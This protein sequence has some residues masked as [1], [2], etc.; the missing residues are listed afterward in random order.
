MRH[1]LNI[2]LFRGKVMFHSQ[3]SFCVFNDPM[4]YQ[5]CDVMMSISTWN[6][7]H[8]RIY[9]LNRNLLSHQTWSIDTYKQGQY[10]SGIFEQIPGPFQFSNLLQVLNNQLCQ[11]SNVL[12]F[13]KDEQG[14]FKNGKCQ[15]L[16]I[17]PCYHF[18]KIIKRP[19]TS[20]Q[21]PPLIW[22]HVINVCDTGH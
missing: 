16:K 13:R 21:S 1:R 6:R 15:L 3:E 2:F 7:V 20:F 12:F 14:T 18:N 19:G 22:K 9:L 10:F 17:S 8:F 5:V 11:D 4:I